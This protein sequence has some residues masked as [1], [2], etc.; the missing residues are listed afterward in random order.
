MGIAGDIAY[1][2]AGKQGTGSFHI[3]VIDAL[4]RMD[5]AILSERAKADEAN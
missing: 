1:E 5:A 3:A 4:S 2:Q